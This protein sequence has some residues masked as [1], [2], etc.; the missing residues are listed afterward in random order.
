VALI[1]D[2]YTVTTSPTLLATIPAGNPTTMVTVTNDDNSSIFI[3]D[4]TVAAS[5]ADKGITVIKNVN[6][7]LA[8]NAGDKLYGI[9]AAGTAANAVTIFYSK[10]VP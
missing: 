8:L 1:H 3:G 9:S 5:G 10:V 4:N 2:S 7:N 6:Y